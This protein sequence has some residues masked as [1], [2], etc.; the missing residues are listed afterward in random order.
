MTKFIRLDIK[1]EWMGNDHVSSVQGMGFEVQYIENFC[2]DN[3]NVGADFE[4]GISCYDLTRK[5][6]ALES[7]F[8]YWNDVAMLRIDDYADMQI[9]IFEGDKLDS[10][11]SDWED[12]AICTK[13]LVEMDAIDVMKRVSE[14]YEMH[15]LDEIDYDEFLEELE[16]I[17]IGV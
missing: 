3:E 11:G 1:G 4:D 13:T 15:E 14:L 7:L 2:L 12:M 8:E 16:K 10:Q 5:G 9:T 17:D 6:M